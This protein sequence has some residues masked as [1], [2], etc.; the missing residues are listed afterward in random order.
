MPHKEG[1]KANTESRID[2]FLTESNKLNLPSLQLKTLKTMMWT[3]PAMS[4]T[5]AE[6]HPPQVLI[7]AVDSSGVK[8]GLDANTSV[9]TV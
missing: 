3:I 4:A 7:P 1:G 9:P 8:R 2:M 6:D 5:Q